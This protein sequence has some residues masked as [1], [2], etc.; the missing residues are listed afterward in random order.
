MSEKR[1]GKWLRRILIAVAAVVVLFVMAVVVARLYFSDGRIA[2]MIAQELEASLGRKVTIDSLALRLLDAS[3]TVKGL[4]VHDK[5]QYGSEPLLSISS[6][7]VSIRVL[8]LLSGEVEIESVSVSSPK[9]QIVSAKDGMLNVE[10]MPQSDEVSNPETAAGDATPFKVES[11]TLDNGQVAYVDRSE[12]QVI[13]AEGIKLSGSVA[14]S[15]EGLITSIG[16]LAGG[17]V[18]VTTASKPTR[19]FSQW[20]SKWEVK[21]DFEQGSMAFSPLSLTADGVTFDGKVEVH[22]I[23]AEAPGILADGKLA[24][25]LSRIPL[26]ASGE[27]GSSGSGKVSAQ[28]SVSG[29]TN[30]L[31]AKVE[32]SLEGVRVP[33][34]GKEA[35]AIG[36]G[37]LKQAIHIGDGDA[38][39]LDGSLSL[40]NLGVSTKKQKLASL[41]IRNKLQTKGDSID[42]ENVSLSAPGAS[43]EVSG[44]AASGTEAAPGPLD[45]RGSMKVSLPQFIEPLVAELANTQGDLEAEFSLSGNSKVPEIHIKAQSD[46]LALTDVASKTRYTLDGLKLEQNTKGTDPANLPIE[47]SFS[48]SMLRIAPA[49]ESAQEFKD[50]R[51]D[52]RLVMDSKQDSL[53]MDRILVSL[54][55]VEFVSSGSVKNMSSDAPRIA[56]VGKGSL[57]LAKIMV[58]ARPFVGMSKDKLDAGGKLDV[59]LNG[60]S[61]TTPLDVDVSVASPEATVLYSPQPGAAAGTRYT[62]GGLKIDQKLA[63]SGQDALLIEGSLSSQQLALGAVGEK[64]RQLGAVNVANRLSFNTKEDKLQIGKLSVSMPGLDLTSSGAVSSFSSDNPA[65]GVKGQA[66]VQAAK[67]IALLRPFIGVSKSELDAGGDLAIDFESRPN[68]GKMDAD[69]K[70]ASASLFADYSSDGAAANRTRY[71]MEELTISEKASGALS[72]ALAVNGSISSKQVKT[73]RAGEKVR[74]LG[75]IAIGNRLTLDS[76]GDSL[77]IESIS[78]SLPG[79]QLDLSGAVEALSSEKPKASAKGTAKL[80]LAELVSLVRPFAGLSEEE[81]QLDGKVSLDI[82]G[83]SPLGPVDLDVRSSSPKV[84]VTYKPKEAEAAKQKEKEA[85]K[86]PEPMN[87]DGVKVHFASQIDEFIY[88]QAATQ[89][90]VIDLLF[91]NS[92]LEVNK[93]DMKLAGGSMEN[94]GSL[95]LDVPGWQYSLKTNVSDVDLVSLSEFLPYLKWTQVTG[96]TGGALDVSGRGTTMDSLNKHLNGAFRFETRDTQLT[97]GPVLSSVGAV[98]GLDVLQKPMPFKEMNGKGKIENGRLNIAAI[99]MKNDDLGLHLQGGV[100]LNGDLDLDLVATLSERLSAKMTGLNQI[101]ALRGS[102]LRIPFKIKGNLSSPKPYPDVADLLKSAVQE[103]AIDVLQG[104]LKKK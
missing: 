50:I 104:L 57:D 52:D 26:F 82:D 88:N 25:D 97:P 83:K 7:V 47:G 17:E 4:T 48:C 92:R 8:P 89:N 59:V 93:A 63:E 29:K 62:L 58:L 76:K 67:L 45:L 99:D 24:V 31:S 90:Q 102:S 15:S 9:L 85:S 19:A 43:V 94:K 16:S 2:G 36:S 54:P 103:Q 20:T 98:L 44:K 27:E 96:K 37:S 13:R 79:I 10:D 53:T 49:G 100:W 46:K 51:V 73:A 12:D 60:R 35:F 65:V 30:D 77:K 6:M 87:Y 18:T 68:A 5:E 33:T 91:E 101:S 69:L 84:V 38:L 41:N 61:L 22:N 1:S 32:A 40:T 11:I 80:E 14:S 86:D 23:E 95:W 75:K 34:D 3:A 74:S 71:T 72:G 39:S 55:G 70:I 66:R 56:L 42:I 21:A 64:P 28:V 78:A 81:L